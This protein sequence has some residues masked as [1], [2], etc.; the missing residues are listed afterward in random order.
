VDLPVGGFVDVLLLPRDP[1]RWPAEHTQHDFYIWWMDERPQVRLVAA[2]P[3]YR[4]EDF[5]TWVQD[6]PSPA[7]QAFLR[8]RPQ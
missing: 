4:R 2:D 5:E 8:Q 1:E 3:R 7:A 6:Q